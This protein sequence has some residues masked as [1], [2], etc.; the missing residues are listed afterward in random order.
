MCGVAATSRGQVQTAARWYRQG[1]A[2]IQG[3]DPGSWSFCALVF[4]TGALGMAGDVPSARQALAEM[5]AVRH[6]AYVYLEP[7]V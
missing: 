1:I 4:L 2:G 6:P 3:S 5:T 7:D